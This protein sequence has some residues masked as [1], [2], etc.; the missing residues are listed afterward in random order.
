MHDFSDYQLVEYFAGPEPFPSQAHHIS[1]R[2]N[3]RSVLD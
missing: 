2:N 3:G 1:L